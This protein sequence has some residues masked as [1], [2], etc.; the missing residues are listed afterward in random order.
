MDALISEYR[1]ILSISIPISNSNSV[2]SASSISTYFDVYRHAQFS[3]LRIYYIFL[4]SNASNKNLVTA[5]GNSRSGIPGNSRESRPPKFTAGIPGNFWNSGRYYG[6]FR[7]FC[8]FFRILMV[9]Y[10]IL[11]FD[12]TAF[13]AKAWMTSLIQLFQSFCVYRVP[14]YFQIYIKYWYRKITEHRQNFANSD[15]YTNEDAEIILI[16]HRPSFCIHWRGRK[17]F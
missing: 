8:L 11:V 9:N 16:G 2:V 15:R 6:E 12:L 3:F 10:D 4:D 5:T 14:V 7:E 13:W 1:Y 17:V